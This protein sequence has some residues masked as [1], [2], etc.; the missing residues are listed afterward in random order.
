MMLGAMT[1][2]L[3]AGSPAETTEAGAMAAEEESGGA[4]PEAARYV[5]YSDERFAAAADSVRVYFF[6]ASWCPTCIAADRQFTQRA[7]EVPMGVIVF[8]IDYD[9]AAD[10]KKEFG[11]TYQHTFVVVDRAGK[12]VRKWNGGDIA[13]LV[14]KTSDLL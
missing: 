12:L 9:T 11:I 5:A 6:H 2:V 14:E 1:P 8:K 3:F 13:A 10:L 4:P 7:A